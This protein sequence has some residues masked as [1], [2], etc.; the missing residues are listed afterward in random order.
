MALILALS[1]MSCASKE[2]RIAEHLKKAREY[3]A[4]EKY[5]AAV[6]E[7]KTVVQMDSKNDEAQFLLGEAY[8]KLDKVPQA[9]GSYASAVEANPGNLKA[10]LKLGQLLL[11]A[12]ETMR[13][14]KAAKLILDKSPNDIGALRLLAA[15]QIQENNV[16]AAIKTLEQAEALQ[17]QNITPRLFLAYLLTASGQL[18]KGEKEY[19]ELITLDPAN[20]SPHV[21]LAMLYARKGQW[22]RTAAVMD[23][24]Q[25]VQGKGYNGLARL[26]GLCERKGKWEIA[27]KIYLKAVAIGA[28][29][30]TSALVNLGTHYARRHNFDQ[31]MATMNRAL[32]SKPDDPTI[33]AD[34]A[35]LNLDLHHID[36]AE[37]AIDKALKKDAQNV[38]A[39]YTKGRIEYLRGNF[40]QALIRFDQTIKDAPDNFMAYYYKALCLMGKGESGHL[41]TNLFQAA[42]GYQDDAEAWV[43]KQA[44]ENLE[45]A[46]KLNPRLLKAKLVLAS[47]FIQN[48]ALGKAQ[49]QIEGALALAPNHLQALSLLG[50]LKILQHDL[51]GAEA[52]CKRVLSGNPRLSGWH[53]RL[54]IVYTAMKRPEEA[55]ASFQRA[56]ALNPSQLEALDGMVGIHLKAHHPQKG[57]DA[58]ERQKTILKGNP[59]ALAIIDQLEG[60]IFLSRGDTKNAM[61]HLKTAIDL[62]PKF[63]APRMALAEICRRNHQYDSAI[64][65]YEAAL[66][67]NPN[68]LPACMALGDMHYKRGD[69][70]AAEKYYRRALKIKSGYAPAANN[71]AFI[72]S[73]NSNRLQEAYRLSQIAVQK[74][75]N[76][77]D[78]M[79]TM[80]WIQY[81][82][83]NYY[84]AIETLKQS[85]AL[86]P[87]SPSAHYHIGLAYYKNREFDKARA[88]LRKALR[89]DPEF[90]GADAARSLLDE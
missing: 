26:A 44:T 33:L 40:Q 49:E 41:G 64:S 70:R 3:Y 30:E 34:I 68:Y 48:H 11:A 59:L 20:P 51:K 4:A 39:T 88:H 27:E 84:K 21:A 36:A 65:H 82:M 57:L 50:G 46:L 43:E 24:M 13:A 2:E 76:D 73:G 35:R 18:E 22:D 61:A 69:K 52:I 19:L 17:P 66:A 78:V 75:P 81:L 54:G 63:V 60:K 8:M 85:L 72:L 89:L 56:L 31:A 7:L 25:Q 45:K 29:D 71:L 15:V 58:C 79:D 90:E 32:A 74:M 1:M 62:A 9:A 67:A 53:L 55:L 42:A 16:A 38:L 14:H 12:K 5:D 86:N 37:A 80:G 77:A 10:Q 87:R 83:G 6:L 28:P 23:R 47:I